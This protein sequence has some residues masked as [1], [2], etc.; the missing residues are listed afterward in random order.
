MDALSKFVCLAFGFRSSGGPRYPCH[1]CGILT[2]LRNAEDFSACQKCQGEYIEIGYKGMEEKYPLAGKDER[3]SL[4]FKEET[5]R[6]IARAK[7]LTKEEL[8]LVIERGCVYEK[9][10]AQAILDGKT[11]T[12]NEMEWL[13]QSAEQYIDR[14]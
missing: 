10:Y 13:G 2:T 6:H 8:L 4:F 14:W 1:W 9:G 5:E 3:N 7:R 11:P 12:E